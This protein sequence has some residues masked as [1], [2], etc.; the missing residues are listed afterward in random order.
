MSKTFRE[1]R[2]AFGGIF[3]AFIAI[4]YTFDVPPLL[5]KIVVYVSPIIFIICW[6]GVVISEKFEVL[7]MQINEI[8]KK[9]IDLENLNKELT[10]NNNGLKEMITGY[11]KENQKVIS[12]NQRMRHNLQTYI[13]LYSY[14][15]AISS[16]NEIKK[17]E[18][19]RNT[20]NNL[21]DQNRTENINDTE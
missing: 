16:D 3:L 4:Y 13:E 6:I 14:F 2:A 8:E 17:A 18:I 10:Q 12:E 11:K 9:C 21:L 7:K 19:I 15:I 20:K 5:V 1:V